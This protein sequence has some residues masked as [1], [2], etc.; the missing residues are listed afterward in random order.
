MINEG[1]SLAELQA[2]VLLASPRET[3]SEISYW[4]SWQHWHQDIADRIVRGS[5][6]FMPTT[7]R[8]SSSLIDSVLKANVKVTS[9]GTSLR[10]KRWERPSLVI[11]DDPYIT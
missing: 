7:R 1:N 11:I 10:V 8:S 5:L 2:R 4:E 6:V 9:A 3:K